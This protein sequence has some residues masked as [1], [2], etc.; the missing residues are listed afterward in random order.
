[1]K[2]TDVYR[3]IHGIVGPW[4]KENG[5]KRAKSGWL[6]YQKP[7]AGKHL[8]F[9]FQCDKWGWDKYSGSSFTVEFQFH[10]SRELGQ[11]SNERINKFLT[12]EELDD[13][14]A[15]QNAIIEKIPPPPKAWV[16]LFE[17]NARR[18]YENPEN[19][20][21]GF[22]LPWTRIDEPFQ[23]THDLW[24][25]YWEHEDVKAWAELVLRVLPRA[26]AQ[27]TTK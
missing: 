8:A 18:L 26:L 22:W 3:T 20:L 27:V 6:A 17:S 16:D 11:W 23:P 15:R 9:W 10:E 4:A 13:A 1:M 24:L 2:S 25:R 21:S 19:I 5:F 12:R 7:Y 14:R